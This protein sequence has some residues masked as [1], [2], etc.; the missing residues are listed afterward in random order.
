MFLNS[1]VCKRAGEKNSQFTFSVCPCLKN[2]TLIQ[3]ISGRTPRPQSDILISTPKM[4]FTISQVTNAIAMDGT[5][6]NGEKKLNGMLSSYK[7][8][9]KKI[10]IYAL[11]KAA[12]NS[13]K[14][15][16]N[17][18]Y[19]CQRIDLNSLTKCVNMSVKCLQNGGINRHD[20]HCHLGYQ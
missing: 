8:S 15:L 13:K 10:A 11:N 20:F 12:L 6:W 9:R 17:R 5:T 14:I 7:I 1:L 4:S 2:S 3:L 19:A 16:K 18:N